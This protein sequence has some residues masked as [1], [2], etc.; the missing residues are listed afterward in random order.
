M[1]FEY[2]K[3][4]LIAQAAKI[5]G[6]LQPGEEMVTAALRYVIS[7]PVDPVAIPGC[8]SPEQA[9]MN[10]A[11][12]ERKLSVEEVNELIALVE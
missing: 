6:T 11:A 7:H 4:A 3:H 2:F 8:K 12:G 1:K 10:A 5:G 9:A